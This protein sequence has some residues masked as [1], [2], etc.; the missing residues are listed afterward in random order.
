MNKRGT[1]GRRKLQTW[2]SRATGRAISQADDG[3]YCPDFHGES[4]SPFLGD[5][6][7]DGKYEENKYTCLVGIRFLMMLLM[8][9]EIKRKF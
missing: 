4:I 9:F 7:N 5:V 6:N 8:Y 3:L 2:G 1:G